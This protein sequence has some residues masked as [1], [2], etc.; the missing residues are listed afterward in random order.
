MMRF[1]AFSHVISFYALSRRQSS[2]SVGFIFIFIFQFEYPPE[3]DEQLE[4]LLDNDLTWELEI[5]RRKKRWRAKENELRSEKVEGAPNDEE[6][7][8][9][10]LYH[11]PNIKNRQPKQVCMHI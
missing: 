6:K 4:D 10:H 9:H 3:E 5:A 11:D 2:S 1:V 7:T 8:L